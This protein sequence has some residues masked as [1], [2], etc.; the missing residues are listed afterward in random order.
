M[1]TYLVLS[2]EIHIEYHTFLIPGYAPG[3]RMY[4]DLC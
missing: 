4:F 2:I 3:C 1:Y